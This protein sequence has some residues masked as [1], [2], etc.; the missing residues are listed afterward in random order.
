METEK[1]QAKKRIFSGVQP[2]G[3]LTIGNY[4]GAI[5]NW[6][7]LQDEY[8]CFYCIVDEHAITV[9]QEPAK[10]RKRSLEVLAKYIAGGVDPD[11]STLFIQS[12]VPQHAQLMWVLN[13][14]AYMG[15]LSR[16]TQYKDKSRKSAENL[17][18]ALF[19]YP[20]LMAADILLYS[21]DLVPVGIDQKQH[22]E[23]A[24]T[25]AER[26]NNKFSPTF[27]IPD[28]YTMKETAKI[29]SLQDAS[30]KMSKS[31]DNL[32]GFISMVDE[33]DVIN[34]KIKKAVTDSVGQ[35]NY[36]DEQPEIKNLINIY[37]AY[38]HKKPQEVVDI[39]QGKNYAEF[40]KDLAQVVVEGITPIRQKYND[41]LKNKDY[42]KDIYKKGAQKA[43]YEA[44]KMISKVYR[45]IGFIGHE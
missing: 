9:P 30:K 1:S 28:I 3:E 36:S 17:N 23:I 5:K 18:A 4:L 43:G 12:H 24:R 45:K 26:F 20:V 31:D 42:L 10:L 21:A 27:V 8:E 39:Y 14:I 2:S 15:E 29:M 41:L 32:N 35:I 40:K 6:V 11:K 44:N 33:N 38:S 7:D 16:M 34:S 19:T 13:S 37:C 22:L 25:L